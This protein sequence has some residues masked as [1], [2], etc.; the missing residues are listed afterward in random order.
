MCILGEWGADG[1]KLTLRGVLVGC[2][3]GVRVGEEAKVHLEA[4]S[5]FGKCENGVEAYCGRIGAKIV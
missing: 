1:G 5:G 2:V 4:D 3:V